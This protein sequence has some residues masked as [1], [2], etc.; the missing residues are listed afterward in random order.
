MGGRVRQAVSRLLSALANWRFFKPAVFLACLYP[1]LDLGWRLWRFFD[2]TDL[3]GLGINP[4]ETLL[5]ETGI[6]ALTIL[7]LTLSVTPLRRLFKVN[8]I[9]NVR[10]MLGV[11]SFV[12]AVLH[13]SSY[14]VFDQ[15]CYA[16]ETCDIRTI[17]QDI[18]SRRFI[19]VGQAAFAILLVLAVT[20]T[21]GWQRR[22]RKNWGRLHKLVYL[23]AGLGVVHF[24]WIQKSDYSEPF[25]WG[26]WLLVLLAIRTGYWLAGRRRRQRAG[27]PVTA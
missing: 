3:T 9:Q 1:A 27:Q 4:N 24:I 15:L 10:R 12:Y 18:L 8:R 20:S 19:F 16:L 6:T 22:L 23:A 17:W 14:L 11:W 26:A 7:L 2:G 13:L 21:T 25:R 5:H